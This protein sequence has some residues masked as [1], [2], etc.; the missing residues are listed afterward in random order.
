MTDTIPLGPAVPAAPTAPVA[1][2]STELLP[3]KTKLAFGVGSAA[4]MI[5]IY[6]VATFAML[7][8]N[9]VLGVNPVWVGLALSVSL[10]FDAITE[11]LVGA[12]SDRTFST[13]FGRRHGWM[14]AS[15]IPIA[16]SFYCIFNPPDLGPLG[17]AIWC[18][19]SVG[20]LR[21]VM[22]FFHT[23]HLALG[24]ELSPHY[25]ERSKVMAYNA[26]FQWVGGSATAWIALTFFFPRTEQFHNGLLNPEPWPQF[27]LAGAIAIIVILYA[28]TIFTM[29]RIPLLPKTAPNTPK[30]SLREFFRD[31]VRALGNV[32]YAWL[33][34]GYFFLSMMVGLREGLRLY[35][36]SFY[37]QINSS[38][39]R[40][41]IIG[42]FIGYILA[43]F[44]A[45][46]MHG[47]FDK[48]ATMIAACLGYA[49]VPAIAPTLGMMGLLKADSPLLL[50][51]LIALGAFGYLAISFLTI[52][53][54]SALADIADENELKHGIRQEGILYSTRAFAGKLDQ[55]VG[56]ALAGFVVSFIAFPRKAT[57]GQVPE[58]VL[59][60][61]ALWDGVVTIVPGVLAAI[62]YGRYRINHTT[63]L[64][65]RRLLAE[66]RG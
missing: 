9:Q 40:W 53:V 57:P 7:F 34:A 22:T 4:E 58:D 27:A 25:T 64:E 65:T 49:I 55:A 12:W 8:Y 61:L 41:F 56:A 24:G 10:V 19:V 44:F 28:S 6:T 26:F 13:R 50:P 3:L 21:Q 48:K 29:D 33:L 39:L 11:P 62:C 35:M 60:N 52:S 5:A 47:R 31:I 20:M 37:W 30:F 16:V 32:S 18:G 1:A 46:R 43:F 15:P 42:S 14:L 36:A 63:Y 2:A 45:A 51:I 54:T 66:R 38:D 59:F 23:P 17:L